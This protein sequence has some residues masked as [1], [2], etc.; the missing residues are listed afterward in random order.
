MFPNEV[1]ISITTTEGSIL[2]F[3]IPVELVRSVTG[4]D[5]KAIAVEIVDRNQEFGVV[6]LPRRSFEG[7]NVARV[8]AGAL[9][10]A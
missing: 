3:F 9:C 5:D 8:P 10:F 4:S 1:A 7:P 6:A 2:S